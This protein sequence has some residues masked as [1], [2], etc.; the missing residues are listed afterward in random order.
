[1]LVVLEVVFG[2]LFFTEAVFGFVRPVAFEEL[3]FEALFGERKIPL[4]LP[5]S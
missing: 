3:F 2:T 1:L 4:L 5:K